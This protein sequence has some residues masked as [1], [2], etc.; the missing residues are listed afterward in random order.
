M[1]FEERW[2]FLPLNPCLEYKVYLRLASHDEVSFRD[3]KEVKYNDISRPNIAS[4]YGG[5]L[6]KE[7]Y[8][9]S[10]CLKEEG[11]VIF[12]DPPEA[13]SK[14]I[15]TRGGRRGHSSR[16]KL[17]CPAEDSASHK[18][19]RTRNHCTGEQDKRLYANNHQT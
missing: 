17:F 14:C 15:L 8:M 11:V 2:G 7:N 6:P 19:G 12:P 10:V 16:T 18:G 1:D 13:I 5:L 3:S 9:G 4:L